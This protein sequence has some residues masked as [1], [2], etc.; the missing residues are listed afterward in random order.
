MLKL[1]TIVVFLFVT[2]LFAQGQSG[3]FKSLIPKEHEL[4]IESDTGVKLRFQFYSDNVIRIQWAK[5]GSDFFADDHY[6]MV[7]K[8]EFNGTYTIIESA[9]NFI[10]TLGEGQTIIIELQKRPM[11]FKILSEKT[12]NPLFS[13]DKGIIWG[14]NKITC[15]FA[16]DTAEHFCGMGHQSFGQV[17]SI[18]LKGKT[19]SCNYG[20][21]LNDWGAQ[22]V[23]TVPFYLSNKG[24]GVFLNST[25][26]HSFSFGND[27]IYEFSIY[28]KGFEGRMDYYFIYGPL[29][30]DILDRYTQL[31]GRPRLP[32]RSIFGLQLSDKGDPE[33]N[34]EEWWKN[35]I[36]AHR[37]A[38]FPFD[39]IV[40][41]NRWR[42]GSGAWSGS[43]FEWDSTRFPDPAEFNKW[44]NEN[45]VTVTLD[46]N[47]NNAELCQGWKP[48]YNLPS[49]EKYV[50]EGTSAPDYSNLEMRQWIWELFWNKSFNPALNYPGDA[51]WI[52]ETDEMAD[53]ND[54]LICAN[55]RSW[56]ENENYYPFLIAKAIVDEGWNN[57]NGSYPPGIGFSKRPF[58]WVR[59]ACAGAQRYITYWTG[60]IYC[61]SDWM[62]YSIRAMQTAGLGGFPYFNHDAGGFRDPGP[63]DNLYIQWSM[64]FGSFTPIWRPHGMG[65]NKRWPLDRSEICQEA[66][67][68]Y[69]KLRYEMMPYIYTYAFNA[70]NTGM[71]IARSMVIDYQDTLYAWK[72]DLQYMWGNEILVAP[73]CSVRDTSLNIWLP[74]GQDWYNY[75]TD[76]LLKGGKIIQ[77]KAHVGEL[78]LF[79]KEG[80]IIPACKYAQ[81]TFSLDP[82]ELIIHVYTGK[83]AVF[84]LYEDDGVSEKYKT[85]NERRT[86]KIEYL[87]DKN[88]L[89]IY[90]PEGNYT[91]AKL[92]R[93]Y[94]LYFHGIDSIQL[95]KMNDRKVHIFN[96]L[97]EIPENESGLFWDERKKM[98]VAV[99]KNQ[100]VN[101]NI[102]LEKL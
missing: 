93:N 17:E 95:F 40:N 20:E 60:D 66:A 1:L 83:D 31:T 97:D 59:S 51:L 2:C 89:I 57:S 30:K 79:V 7:E 14:N 24:Y 41:D 4:T 81:S 73:S 9:E 78:P 26:H 61:N 28:T 84:I 48:E 75:W 19:V 27:N 62:K 64:A 55:G 71:P 96:T 56:A 3:N 92:Q 45:E 23:L 85:G 76:S 90:Q 50:K 32:Q 44:C 87:D 42:S 6:E 10:I 43:W 67:L 77:Y 58:V 54:S 88:K 99:I 70:A 11:R 100:S 25:F 86:T 68:K 37:K 47:R 36:T 12:M 49:S 33:N 91:G 29:F 101:K 65:E 22:A 63:D 94:T 46:H 69:G 38:G 18:D 8:H 21:G 15:H 5:K 34:G 102:V 82:S 74:G 52:D 53:L 98:S 72:Y 80:S 13:E 35:M 16:S 39:H